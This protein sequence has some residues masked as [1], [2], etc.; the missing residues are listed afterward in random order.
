MS[1]DAGGDGGAGSVGSA[2]DE[3]RRLFEAVQQWAHRTSGGA[4]EHLGGWSI[5]TGSPQCQLCPVCQLIGAVRG[6]HPEVVAHLADAAG[7]L[8]AALRAGMDAHERDW[9]ARKAPDVTRIDIG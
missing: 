9:A 7:S 2:A 5:A 1:A 3:A 8:L 4:G 6:T